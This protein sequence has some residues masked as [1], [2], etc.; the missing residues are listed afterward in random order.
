MRKTE[1]ISF[2]S[3]VLV[4]VVAFSIYLYT[5]PEASPFTLR[6]TPESLKGDA[7][8]GQHVIFLV[9]VENEGS[10]QSA[11]AVRIS[12]TAPNSAIAVEPEAISPGQIA[13]V[14]IIP[15]VTSVGNNVTVTIYAERA[16]L[17]H[18]QKVTFTVVEGED[19]LGEYARQIRE[20]FI[21]WL[22]VNHPELA[23]TSETQ[24]SGTVVSPRWLVVSHYLFFS[25]DWEMHVY[26]H[27]MIPPY[28]WARIDLRHRFT[29]VTPSLAFEISSLNA[30]LPPAAIAPPEEIWR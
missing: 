5:R 23:I 16:D 7:I 10:S 9:M 3:I 15:G 2:I 26:W 6:V 29:E 19:S 18:S 30:S 20:T 28:D 12:A 4:A 14:T 25:K 27:I 21:Q 8:A 24:W 22:E 13:E 17:K 11:Q 1:L